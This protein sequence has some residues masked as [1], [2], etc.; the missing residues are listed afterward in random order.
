MKNI[1]HKDD[2]KQTPIGKIPTE[3]EVKKMKEMGSTFSGLT[4]KTKEDFGF[5]KPYIS[6]LNIYNNTVIDSLDF[7]KVKISTSE[8]QHLVESGDVFFTTSSETADEVGISSTYIGDL[9][10]LYLNS[11]CFGFKPNTNT[12]SIFLAN[13]F[14]SPLGRNLIFSL[15]QGATRYN[16]SKSNFMELQIPLPPLPEQKK[17][18]DILSTW[19]LAIEKTQNIILNLKRRNKGLQQQLLTGKKRLNGFEGKEWKNILFSDIFLYI[20]SESLTRADLTLE[21]TENSI[22]CLHYGDIHAK[23]KNYNLDLEKETKIS[24]VIPAKEN[25]EKFNYLKEGD[26]IIADA[27]EDTLD[28]GKSVVL[29]NI[30][31]KKIIG[32]L[33]TI[34]ARDTNSLTSIDFRGYLLQNPVIKNSIKC[35]ATGISVFGISKTNL[36]K[37]NMTIPSIPEQQAIANVLNTAERELRMY[38][39]KMELLQTQKKGLM[40]KLLTGEVRVKI[41]G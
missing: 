29:K 8:K 2:Y 35:I 17:I 34:V 33:H 6:Y 25:L 7:E 11:F 41:N 13:F 16:L 9:K 12:N 27:S 31:N 23:F 20:K 36:S 4:G 40:Q 24:Y 26:L 38:E 30:G 1:Q 5:G 3:W 10:E 39:Q 28:I 15:A 37:I 18:A 21:K 19:D 22:L 32:G 14:R